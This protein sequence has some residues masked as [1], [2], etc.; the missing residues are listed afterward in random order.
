MEDNNVECNKFVAETI[1]DFH[2]KKKEIDLWDYTRTNLYKQLEEQLFS[3][4]EK[5]E[6]R[7][8]TATNS[9]KR[10]IFCKENIIKAIEMN[11]LMLPKLTKQAILL[12]KSIEK[13][14]IDLMV[15]ESILE[16]SYSINSLL[17]VPIF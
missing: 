9:T 14:F 5:Q 12:N 11:M 3:N 13:Y 7:I 6:N 8:L 17:W 15:W 2:N 16:T 4:I 10:E 1:V